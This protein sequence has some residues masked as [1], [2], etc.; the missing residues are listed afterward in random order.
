MAPGA[1]PIGLL[2][3]DFTEASSEE[4]RKFTAG[5]SKRRLQCHIT[6]PNNTPLV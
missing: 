2:F 6:S 5:I 1:L 4:R 3:T